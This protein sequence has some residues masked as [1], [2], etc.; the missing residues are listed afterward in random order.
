M[1]KKDEGVWCTYSNTPRHIR[2]KCWKLHG[3]PLAKNGGRKES[4]NGGKREIL[5]EKEGKY[6]LLMDKV[7]NLSS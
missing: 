5:Q 1:E 6:T 4:K 7:K 2:E 3:K